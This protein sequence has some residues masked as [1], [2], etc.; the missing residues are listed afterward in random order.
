[1]TGVA[2]SNLPTST[3]VDDVLGNSGGNTRR[4]PIDRLVAL[5]AALMGPT[6]AQRSQLFADLNWPAGAIGYVRADGN[7]AFNGVYKK[8]GNSGSGSWSRIG[9]LPTGALELSLLDDIV[10]SLNSF[11]FRAYGTRAEAEAN[12]QALP[13]GITHILTVESYGVAVRGRTAS[14]VDLLFPSGARWGVERR[15]SS[16]DEV[17]AMLTSETGPLRSAVNTGGPIRLSSNSYASGSNTYSAAIDSRF[18]A[19]GLTDIGDGAEFLWVAPATNAGPNPSLTIGLNVSRGM[20]RGDGST[21]PT[22]WIVAN[23]GYVLRRSGSQVLVVRGD[24]TH[25]ELAAEA[26]ARA[27]TIS[28]VLDATARVRLVNVTQVGDTIFGE[29]PAALAALGV[30]PASLTRVQLQAPAVNASTNVRLS[31]NGL[32]SVPVR[33]Y[34]GDVVPVGGLFSG[35]PLTL[36]LDPATG[37]WRITST[38]RP[39]NVQIVDAPAIRRS[40]SAEF[41]VHE[42]VD[43][44]GGLHLPGLGGVAVQDHFRRAYRQIGE[45]DGKAQRAVDAILAR[46]RVYDAVLDFAIPNDGITNARTQIQAAMDFVSAS[47]LS[48]GP[49]VIYFPPGVSRIEGGSVEPRSNVIIQGAGWGRARF[50]PFNQHAAFRRDLNPQTLFRFSMFDVEIDCTNQGGGGPSARTK[51]TY[52][53]DYRECFFE[54]VWCHDAWAT[55]LGNDMA[56]DVWYTD[57]LLQGNGRGTPD[58]VVAGGSSGIGLGTGRF[59]E[60]RVIVSRCISENNRNNGAFVER[61]AGGSSVHEAIGVIFSELICRENA[62]GVT[63][64]GGSGMIIANCQLYNNREYGVALDRGTLGG[65]PTSNV[66]HPGEYTKIIGNQIFGNL[67]DGIHLIAPGPAPRRGIQTSGNNIHRNGRHG[68]SISRN[69]TSDLIGT[70]FNGDYI[71]QN[72]GDG[73]RVNAGSYA[74]LV[75]KGASLVDNQGA[76]IRVNGAVRGG[77][78]F[79][80]EIY[81]TV[82]ESAPTASITGTGALTGVD[83]A[84]NHGFGVS[85]ISLTGAQSGV[86]FGRNPGI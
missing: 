79:G 32:T 47:A 57:C 60:E 45:T 65:S 12:A 25:V 56:R 71:A 78:I 44:G 11:G 68:I 4:I 21:L 5:I 36:D 1:M 29:I 42:Y 27:A 39:P 34:T 13:S 49:G 17:Q 80:N 86:T 10:V 70:Q 30:T 35:P 51:G 55:G 28:T 2:T 74:G 9:D 22:G 53:I 24:V 85:P 3:T 61:Q 7:T 6:Y 41:V 69:V 38:E 46:R 84:E 23:R 16:I 31:I 66:P 37:F 19:I 43:F 64:A 40:T 83:I 15:L 67:I 14:S 59:P 33:T 77:R 50:L 26:S 75:I 62:F 54:R 58:D 76:G 72:A 82:A 73:I 20:R 18:A 63:D 8:S 81:N 48:S 52:I